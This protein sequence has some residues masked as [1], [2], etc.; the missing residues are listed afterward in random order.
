MGRKKKVVPIEPGNP[1]KFITIDDLTRQDKDAV[2]VMF[3][4]IKS[5]SSKIDEDSQIT[6]VMFMLDKFNLAL[7]RK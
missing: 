5:L 4:R 7:S 2:L 1:V 3:N 6:E